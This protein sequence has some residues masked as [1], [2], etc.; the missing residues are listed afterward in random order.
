MDKFK[1]VTKSTINMTSGIIKQVGSYIDKGESTVEIII[2]IIIAL[3]IVIF[4]VWAY[5]ITQQQNNEC[6]K[7]NN[8]YSQSD[9]M[10]KPIGEINTEY[11]DSQQGTNTVAYTKQYQYKAKS[12]LDFSP[13]PT[14]PG[15][16]FSYYVKT[17]YNCCSPGG[18]K[19]S[20]VDLCA[21][22]HAI[23]LGARCLDFEIYSEDYNPVVATSIESQT[24]YN[25]FYIKETFNSLPLMDV[26]WYINLYALGE[27]TPN[28]EG[29]PNHTDPLFLHLRIMTNELTT[30]NL[31]AK[32]LSDI[33]Q[34]KLLGSAYG[35]NPG[36]ENFNKLPLI[37]FCNKCIIMV[38]YNNINYQ[39]ILKSDLYPLINLMTHATNFNLFREQTLFSTTSTE[40]LIQFN[41]NNVTIVLPNLTPGSANYDPRP[42]MQSGCQ[43]VAMNFQNFDEYLEVYFEIFDDF[44]Y[45]F[46]LKECKLRYIPQ[47]ILIDPIPVIEHNSACG[48]SSSITS[49]PIPGTISVSSAHVTSGK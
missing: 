29:A 41:K 12:P 16:L 18:F 9:K 36:V 25:S 17:A 23:Q 21:L 30:I 42:A 1:D 8:I 37:Q 22:R 48:Q 46:V 44:Q 24:L 10:I 2:Y 32:Y 43:F 26:L 28:D 27:N 7:L 20:F 45:S 34:N 3:V 15:R 31:I 39:T 6:S 47:H 49:G 5:G 38:E 4:I 35:Y 11:D 33:F 19:N 13:P 14:G 40:Q